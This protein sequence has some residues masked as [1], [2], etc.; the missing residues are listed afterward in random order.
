MEIFFCVLYLLLFFVLSDYYSKKPTYKRYLIIA[1]I[2]SIIIGCICMAVFTTAETSEFVLFVF[3][4]VPMM[5]L[6][7]LEKCR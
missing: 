5:C 1:M 2:S 6:M 7:K 4:S 3:W